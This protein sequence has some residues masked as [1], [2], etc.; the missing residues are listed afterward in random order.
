MTANPTAT[1]QFTGDDGTFRLASPHNTSYLYFPLVNEAGM[2]SAITPGLHGDIKTDQNHFLSLPVSVEDLHNTRSPRDFWVQIAGV[3]PWSVA[4][5]SAR[6]IADRYTAEADEVTVE[7]G[8]LWHKVIRRHG[9]CGLQAEVLNFVPAGADRVELMQVT[10][11][12]VGDRNLRLTPIAAVPLFGRSA[13]NLRDHRHVTSLLHRVRCHTHGIL[14]RPTMSFDERG[15]QP[16]QVTYAV[17]GVTETGEAPAGFWPVVEDFIGEGGTL[18]W[19][20]AI[21]QA[22]PPPCR[23]GDTVDG[24]EALA[25][26]QFPA[27]ELAPGAAQSYILILAILD[28]ESQVEP[29]LARYGGADQCR[30]WLSRTRDF[31]AQKL[32]TL[33]VR[34]ADPCFDGWLRWVAVQPTLRRLFGNSFLPYHDYGR[35]GRGWRDLWQD[36][37]AILL[38]EGDDVG[39]T[40]LGHFA[41]VRLDGSNATIIGSRP[42]EFKAD[43]NNIPRV[44]MDHGAWPL[45]TVRLYIDQSGDLGFL[46]REQ[47]YFKDQNTHRCRRVDERW[48][49]EQGTVQ[50]TR[51]G[52]A[53]QGSV[54]EHLLVQHLTAFHHVGEHNLILLEGADW[55]DGLDMARNRG[56]SVAF[57]AMYAWNLWQ[58][59]DLVEALAGRGVTEVALAAELS[60]LLSTDALDDAG[61]KRARL[62]A[63]FDAV[64]TTVSGEKR[65][66]R[67]AELASTLRTM[68]NW[69][70]G[71]IRRQEWLSDEAGRGWFNG[72]YDDHG[73]RVEGVFGDR[74]RMTLT[75]QVFAVMGGVADEA[76]TDAALAAADHYLYDP[77]VGGYRLNTDFGEVKLDLGRAFGFA[78]GHKENGAM[79]SHMTVMFANALYRRGR[80][81][82]GW[83]TL[84]DIYRQ[85]ANFGVSRMYPGIPEYFSP[86]GRG[87]YPW[88]TGSASWYILTLVQWAYGV[89]GELGDLLLA[90]Q[91]Q[92]E[93]FDAGGVAE[94]ATLFAGRRLHIRYVNPGRLPAAQVR[95]VRVTVDGAVVE[96]RQT[97]AGLRLPR[98]VILNLSADRPHTLEV[99]LG[100]RDQ[101]AA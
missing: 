22:L 72:Y 24:Y 99:T 32:D 51:A 94:V 52:A 67:P 48:T 38:L 84:H 26:L 69:L 35:G 82:A 101:E 21:V 92:P 6:Q 68:G 54:L 61:R 8:F 7:A 23:P 3:G 29:L 56:E 49:P 17:L 44:W 63:Y 74:V 64:A 87:M 100:P 85:S 60:D 70:A 40:L 9:R 18:D 43:R 31:W 66:L 83:R 80:A 41:G 12:N 2:M 88:L 76:Q 10:L 1:W 93:Q 57:S 55:N 25:G 15:H 4:G 86:R 27:I 78:F 11:T 47:V 62:Q 50:Q 96:A 13:D 28:D 53:Y 20:Q 45:L 19:P 75:G 36:I 79:F 16:N 89:R 33:R 34:S 90:P 42:G 59:A 39:E 71:H 5:N 46:L 73:R 77:A 30:D 58:L 98:P 97:A 95:P 91:L 37:L 65:S 14:L 81:K